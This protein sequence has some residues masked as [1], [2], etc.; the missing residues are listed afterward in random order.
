MIVTNNEFLLTDIKRMCDRVSLIVE[1]KADDETRNMY[2]NN[3]FEGLYIGNFTEKYN[4]YTKIVDGCIEGEI[5]YDTIKACASKALKNIKRLWVRCRIGNTYIDQAVII[6]IGEI[7]IA[8]SHMEDYLFSQKNDLEVCISY[9]G[10]TMKMQNPIKSFQDIRGLRVAVGKN[11]V[12]IR[13]SVRDG[14]E[15]ELC[16]AWKSLERNTIYYFHA[17][18]IVDNSIKYSLSKTEMNQLG[19]LKTDNLSF[20]WVMV[21]AEGKQYKLYFDDEINIECSV[22]PVDDY[23]A[24]LYKNKD[25]AICMH[26]NTS[27]FFSYVGVT[28]DG[29]G[30]R[31]EFPKRSYDLK[32]LSILARR[33]NTD[34]EYRLPFEM[35]SEDIEKITYDIRLEFG[36]DEIEDNFKTGI[37]QFFVEVKDDFVS[38]RYP[39]KLFR[40]R[41]IKENTYIV[42]APPYSVIGGHYHNCLF[43]SDS[44]NNLKCNI[45]PKRMKLQLFTVTVAEKEIIIPYRIKKEAYFEKISEIRLVSENGD[46]NSVGFEDI[47]SS[48]GNEICGYMLIPLWAY[49]TGKNYILRIEMCFNNRKESLLVENN[50]FRPAVANRELC[51]FSFLNEISKGVYRR[52]WGNHVNGSYL[53]GITEDAGLFSLVGMWIYEEDKICIR[54]DWSDE[55]N[56]DNYDDKDIRLH[57][58]NVIT[59]EQIEFDRERA[60][61]DEIIFRLPLS[62]VEDKVFLVVAIMYNGI[63]SYIENKTA[64]YTLFS[65]TVAKKIVLK[66]I[67]DLLYI[68]VEKMLLCESLTKIVECQKIISKAR[69]ENEGGNRKIWLIG[70]NY[71]LSARDNGLAFFEYCMEHLDS[72]NAEVYFVSKEENEDATVLTAYKEHVIIYDSPRHIYLDELAEFYV[73]SHG[74]RDVMPSLYHNSMSRYR[75]DVIYLQHGVTAIKKIT[76]S[77]K[78]YGGSIRRFVVSSEQEKEFMVSKKQ[79]WDDEIIVSGMARYDKLSCNH[80]QDG[81]YI[82]I[83][84]TW[85]D[86]LVI[87]SERE[88]VYSDFY[89]YYSRVLSSPA[90]IEALQKAGHKLVFSLH[91]EFEKYKSLFSKYENDVVHI[92]DM[93]EQSLNK[94]IRECSMVVTD[95]SSIAFDVIY[96]GRPVLFFQYD[97]DIYNKYRGSYINLETDLPGKVIYD[98]ETM[99][100]SLITM[101]NN[102]FPLDNKY[103]KCSER[104]FDFHDSNN[105]ERIYNAIIECREE[106]SDVY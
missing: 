72:I 3:Y 51:S 63:M 43:Y 55:D 68:S 53:L 97:Q 14:L 61:E 78:S 40:F 86:W 80:Q 56:K 46:V 87:E 36:S 82:W 84:P 5:L 22:L 57:L 88:F 30:L 41:Q 26:M 92:T 67:N 37:Y 59:G 15:G 90:L 106:I 103:Q 10:E 58:K 83:M 21:D 45:V 75:K 99:I 28:Y 33:V 9:F 1:L 27:M 52:I 25:G 69:E 32:L 77:N 11:E 34:I 91:I 2:L 89:I 93:H 104:Y 105:S 8:F 60:V 24:Q 19:K 48:Y 70:E 42:F 49:E 85:R 94:R 6:G 65:N 35:V 44:S 66:R 95:Y 79:F 64:T 74:I 23:C 47:A 7:S 17:E 100:D 62:E 101:I 38:E 31:L 96:L 18:P 16:L 13:A 4:V 50:I 20:E 39:L 71:G 54:I 98:L 76:I 73:V 81:K 102:G 12:T 29:N